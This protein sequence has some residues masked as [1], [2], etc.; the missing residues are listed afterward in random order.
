MR[1]ATVSTLRGR[2]VAELSALGIKI[3]VDIDW[4]PWVNLRHLILNALNNFFLAVAVLLARSLTAC[5]YSLSPST[6]R[7]GEHPCGST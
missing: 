2:R 4:E 6:S 7:M 5:E 1:A 3:S